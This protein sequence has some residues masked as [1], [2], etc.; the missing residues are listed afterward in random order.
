M[1]S[2]SCRS[3]GSKFTKVSPSPPGGQR[4]YRTAL[5]RVLETPAGKASIPITE[6]LLLRRLLSQT[7]LSVAVAARGRSSN[8][9]T[10][11]ALA[12]KGQKHN[13]N[14]KNLPSHE[15]EDG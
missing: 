1:E 12:S 4:R 15:A 13:S 5:I 9:G 3:G 11:K 10:L 8:G 2:E 7:V 14:E 6:L